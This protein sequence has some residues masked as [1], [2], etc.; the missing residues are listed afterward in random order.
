MK[1]QKQLMFPL[2]Q[3]AKLSHME[4]KGGKH[5]DTEST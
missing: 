4:K 3:K 5:G 2:Y 1:K